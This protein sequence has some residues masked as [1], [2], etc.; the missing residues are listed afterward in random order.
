[1]ETA[2]LYAHGET[3]LWIGKGKLSPESATLF[4]EPSETEAE[5]T[6]NLLNDVA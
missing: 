1:M 4:P 2:V 5:E 6:R 3:P